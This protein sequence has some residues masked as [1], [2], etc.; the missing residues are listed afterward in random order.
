MRRSCNAKK[1]LVY[2]KKLCLILLS[3]VS[4]LIMFLVILPITLRPFC[5]MISKLF[6]LFLI[7][8]FIL[9][10]L[11]QFFEWYF[12]PSTFTWKWYFTLFDQPFR[13]NLSFLESIPFKFYWILYRSNS[14]SILFI[15]FDIFA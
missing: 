1:K 11:D 13:T 12:Y 2:F 6:F 3:T 15:I 7:Y 4:M 14:I 10:K 8:Y 5:S 9:F